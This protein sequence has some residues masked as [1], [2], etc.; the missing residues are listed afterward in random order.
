[1][2]LGRLADQAREDVEVGLD[3]G[4]TIASEWLQH[5]TVLVREVG[6]DDLEDDFEGRTQSHHAATHPTCSYQVGP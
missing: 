6:I 5:Q 4:G 2:R 3:W 1:M